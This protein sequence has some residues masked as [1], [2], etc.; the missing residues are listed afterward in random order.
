MAWLWQERLWAHLWWDPGGPCWVMLAILPSLPQP[1]ASQGTP[2]KALKWEQAR[3]WEPGFL[4]LGPHLEPSV[5]EARPGRGR[6][7]EGKGK[8]GSV[9]KKK[10]AIPG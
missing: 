9:N 3:A 6:S 2:P 4:S 1:E 8:E 10:S 7:W 5:S